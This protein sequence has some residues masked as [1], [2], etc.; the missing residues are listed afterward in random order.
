[1]K[2]I[3]KKII[4]EANYSAAEARTRISDRIELKLEKISSINYFP[5]IASFVVSSFFIFF[6]ISNYNKNKRYQINQRV[7]EIEDTDETYFE[8]ELKIASINYSSEVSD[9][10][11]ESFL[12]DQQESDNIDPVDSELNEIEDV[13]EEFLITEKK[14]IKKES[15]TKEYKDNYW[16]KRFTLCKE[17]VN[18]YC[19]NS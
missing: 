1:M 18:F 9:F 11:D 6:T 17:Q 2:E 14:D 5:V 7:S 4:D 10:L 16:E 15:L 19:L 8:D 12:K 13:Y 3:V